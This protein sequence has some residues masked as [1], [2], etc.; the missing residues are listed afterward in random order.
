MVDYKL[1]CGVFMIFI[2]KGDEIKLEYKE[3]FYL[4]IV[5]IEKDLFECIIYLLYEKDLKYIDEEGVFK[6][7]FL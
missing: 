6:I 2:N 5:K 7:G 3:K 4:D 1:S